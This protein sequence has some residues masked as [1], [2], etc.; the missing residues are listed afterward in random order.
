MVRSGI[1]PRDWAGD[2]ADN[3]WRFGK[4]R[5]V[6][7][8]LNPSD[9]LPVSADQ[10]P[11]RVAGMSFSRIRGKPLANDDGRPIASMS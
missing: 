10:K 6:A 7:L 5:W 11:Y 9:G 8:P 2:A 4:K 3:R 1:S